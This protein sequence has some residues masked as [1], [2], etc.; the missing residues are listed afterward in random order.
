MVTVLFTVG[1]IVTVFFTV[2]RIVTV[3]FMGYIMVSSFLVD[4]N[5]GGNSLS[6]ILVEANI[7]GAF[8]PKLKELPANVSSHSHDSGN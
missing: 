8:L 5:I 7:T 1:R 6:N 4:V 3:D 2:G